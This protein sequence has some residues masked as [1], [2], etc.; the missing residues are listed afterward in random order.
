MT[1][2]L[3]KTTYLSTSHS[4]RK[5]RMHHLRGPLEQELA[6][7]LVHRWGWLESR[8]L[9]AVGWFGSGTSLTI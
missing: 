1:P 6:V 5:R 4:T 2:P 3:E 8:A 9:L 7:K